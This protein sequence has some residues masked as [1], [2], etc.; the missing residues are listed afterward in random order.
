MI[1]KVYECFGG[2]SDSKSVSG[3]PW[4]CTFYVFWYMLK[5]P[6][7]GDKYSPGILPSAALFYKAASPTEA[8]SLS[9]TNLEEKLSVFISRHQG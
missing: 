8:G 1:S 5:K 9:T 4:L 3:P 6:S 7:R 2:L